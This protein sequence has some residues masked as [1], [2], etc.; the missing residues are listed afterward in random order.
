MHI[1]FYLYIFIYL[2]TCLLFYIIDMLF[3]LFHKNLMPKK[4]R[5]AHLECCL[6]LV[7]LKLP[8]SLLQCETNFV[9]VV[10]ANKNFSKSEIKFEL[11]H[12]HV[13][14]FYLNTNCVSTYL[15]S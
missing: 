11:L 5:G 12:Y 8:F 4:K 6:L 1:F 13:F 2:N 15:L 7:S 3:V 10:E 14:V 9:V